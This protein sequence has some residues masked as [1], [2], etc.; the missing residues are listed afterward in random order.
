[1][2][3]TTSAI[4]VTSDPLPQLVDG[5]QLRTRSVSVEINRPDFEFNATNCSQQAIS[6][7]ITGEHAIGSSEAAKSSAVSSPY[8][9]SGCANLP[10]KPKLTALAAGKASKANGTSFDVK[11]ESAGLGQANIA[12]VDL[13]LPKALPSRLTT[14]QKACLEAVFDA[15]PA[16]CDEGSVIGKAT[17]HTPLLSSPLTGPAYLVSHG[18]AAFPDVEFVLQ[19]EGITLVLDGK[20]D[21]KAGITYSRFETNPDAP[22]TTFE[23]E[24][25]AGPHSALTADVPEAEEFSLCKTSLSMPT[26]LTGQN[27]GH[28]AETTNIA[29]TGCGGVLPFKATKAEL[30]AKALKACKTKYKG[31][32]KK[33]KRLACEKQAHKRY[34]PKAKAKKKT[35][36]KAAVGKGGKR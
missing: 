33:S 35:G 4:T 9:A 13:Q 5:V 30:L 22:F 32:K 15:N 25:P 2:N 11:V 26:E 19:G 7:T 20:T 3:P 34:G 17:V 36:K 14:I 24:L 21:I 10:F 8:A 29:V 6:G 18:G 1:V 31:K 16:S 23:T 28:L 12:K 27:G